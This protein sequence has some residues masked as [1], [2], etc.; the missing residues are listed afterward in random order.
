MLSGVAARR[1]AATTR[2]R[3]GLGAP[4]RMFESANPS[5][6]R[7]AHDSRN[8]AASAQRN[9]SLH[10]GRRRLGTVAEQ[11]RARVGVRAVGVHLPTALETRAQHATEARRQ[12]FEEGRGINEAQPRHREER[13]DR[14]AK[15]GTVQMPIPELHLFGGMSR[16]RND[17]RVR[18]RQPNGTRI[19]RRP[20]LRA[21]RRARYAHRTA[22]AGVSLGRQ[23]KW[24]PNRVDVDGGDG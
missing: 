13:V 2:S 1:T 7:G 15:A 14:Q 17:A 5:K 20:S 19:K 10:A 18:R 16:A 9:G 6:L 24:R 22:A 12:D 3:Y 11:K 8:E 23:A 4:S 21:I